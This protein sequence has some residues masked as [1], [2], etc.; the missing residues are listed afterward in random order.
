MAGGTGRVELTPERDVETIDGR[1]TAT[2]SEPW[3][4]PV[5]QGLFIAG[6]HVEIW[7]RLGVFDHPAR[8]V[9]RFWTANGPVDRLLPGPVAGAGTWA[10]R[11]PKG[12]TRVSISPVNRPGRFDF[13]LERATPV[14]AARLLARGLMKSPGDAIG[15]I[16]CRA[17]GF[18]P[19]YERNLGWATG[20]APLDD[21]ADW[22]AA[23]Q[24]PLEPVGMDA[25]R[26]APDDRARV[27]ATIDARG[28]T[29]AAVAATAA[30][31]L[32]QTHGDW[33]ARVLEGGEFPGRADGRFAPDAPLATAGPAL[34]LRLDAGDVLAPEAFACLAEHR[35]RFPSEDY[36]YADEEFVGPNGRLLPRFKPAW[37][38][39][40][41]SRAPYTGRLCAAVARDPGGLAALLRGTDIAP[42]PDAPAGRVGRIARPLM[43]AARPYDAP[44]PSAT[45]A[46]PSRGAVS[47]VIPNKDRLS[48]LKPCLD[49]VFNVTAA[50][51]FE[52]VVVDNGS[53]E[54][55]TRAYY[56]ELRRSGRPI[57]VVSSPG[58]FNFSLLCNVGARAASAKVDTL[59]FLNND[60][61][62]LRADWIDRL[63]ARA[64]EPGVGAVG[65]KL[66]F[67][68]GDVQHIDLVLGLQGDAGLVDRRAA[69]DE[70][71]WLSRNLVAHEA[72]AVA[73]ACLAV[74]REKFEAVGGFD[75]ALRVELNDVDLCLRLAS[76]G[77]RCVSD[78]EVVLLHR[79]G[80]SRGGASLQRVSRH[81]GDRAVFFERW[82]RIDR[83]DPFFHPGFS[84]ERLKPA[85]S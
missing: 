61:E 85:L 66:L 50:R 82:G 26:A 75:E 65:G 59:V 38:P 12:A 37:S 62:A 9:L 77:W 21:Y 20:F 32:A 70:A 1:W 51:D 72:S 7:Y 6:A 19:E 52:V 10:G 24:R 55:A 60:T 31:L 34:V 46:P 45:P 11:V 80:A 63:A 13:R 67:P 29:P 23:R 27:F 2:S 58:P 44:R 48:L 78:S 15:A 8:P 64:R 17:I 41:R 54:A 79:E 53:V 57:R 47:I 30:S 14:G 3:L 68:A 76:R 69:A 25:P 84:L 43:R 36:F 35:A 42:P 16:A 22:K 5:D 83:D 4:A 33:R 81:G 49:T 28:A 56:D 40:L 18:D 39:T 71:G 73:A 74:A